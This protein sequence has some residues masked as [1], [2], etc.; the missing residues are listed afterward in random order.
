MPACP[1]ACAH[2]SRWLRRFRK[3]AGRGYLATAREALQARVAS[4]P[5][6]CPTPCCSALRRLA[7][8]RDAGSRNRRNFPQSARDRP[9]LKMPV[10]EP[11]SGSKEVSEPA[12]CFLPR[13]P[14]LH[15]FSKK[16]A[17]L[18]TIQEPNRPLTHRWRKVHVSVRR[19]EVGVPRK[20]LDGLRRSSP[21]R[22]MRA[23]RMPEDVGSFGDVEVRSLL[24]SSEP[25]LQIAGRHRLSQERSRPYHPADA[26]AR[27]GTRKGTHR[28]W[29]I[30]S[31]AR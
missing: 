13:R 15:D 11:F 25:S 16:R 1:S 9:P 28:S 31:A 26:G 23:E 17:V 30:R 24:C 3:P 27:R 21:H 4:F 18:A 29:R 5:T 10:S 19:R 14:R 6:S 2:R 22:Q 7:P 12:R 8:C 20:L